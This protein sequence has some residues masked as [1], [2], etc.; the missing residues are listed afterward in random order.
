MRDKQNR[1]KIKEWGDNIDMGTCLSLEGPK[2]WRN[3]QGDS[4]WRI[5]PERWEMVVR[6]LNA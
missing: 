3:C 1:E 5:E 6:V 2:R 4:S